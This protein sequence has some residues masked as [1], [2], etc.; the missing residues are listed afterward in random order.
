MITVTTTWHHNPKPN[1]IYA[2]LARK[3]GREPTRAELK[4][5]WDRILLQEGAE[6]RKP[7]KTRRSR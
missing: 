1:S 2:V 6:N 3:L 4:A 7:A 5:D